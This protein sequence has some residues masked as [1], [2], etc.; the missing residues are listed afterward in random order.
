M[1]PKRKQPAAKSGPK[2]KKAKVV[3]EEPVVEVDPI[4]AKIETLVD[5]IKNHYEGDRRVKEI[6]TLAATH[7]YEKP[8]ED[9]HKFYETF[10]NMVDETL[11]EFIKTH[12]DLK[13]GAHA[14]LANMDNVK[15]ANITKE[16]E[17]VEKITTKQSEI[18]AQKT[19]IEEKEQTLQ[20][21][22]DVLSEKDIEATNACEEK[23]KFE[24][25]LEK[26]EEVYA[27]YKTLTD[28]TEGAEKPSGKEQKKLIT[29]IANYLKK[30][31]AASS[32]TVAVPGILAKA[33]HAAF[34][35]IVLQESTRVFDEKISSLKT[36][37]SEEQAKTAPLVAEKEAASTSANAAREDLKTNEEALVVLETALEELVSEKKEVVKALKNHNKEVSK[38]TAELEEHTA[39]FDKLSEVYQTEQ[40]LY[41]RSDIVAEVPVE[42]APV[43]EAVEEVVVVDSVPADAV[44]ETVVEEDV[45]MKKEDYTSKYEENLE[46]VN[47]DVELVEN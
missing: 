37:I 30:I 32:L 44:M 10:H 20:I 14:K 34:D 35:L 21:A 45:T 24:E 46:D 28:A 47:T 40:E 18:D 8:R 39:T 7:T 42:E 17:L 1:A 41:N 25:D 12:K 9:R 16:T 2:A 13:E 11:L 3:V 4:E 33:E 29:N 26:T 6:L 31:G 43:E 27:S 5:T 19:L 38:I 22:E 36:S 23:E 15:E